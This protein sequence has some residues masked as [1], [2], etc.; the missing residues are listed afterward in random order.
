MNNPLTGIYGILIKLTLIVALCGGIYGIY[1]FKVHQAVQEAVQVVNVQHSAET[2]RQKEIIFDKSQKEKDK[3]QQDFDKAQKEK[4][5]KIHTLN[6]D[7][8]N[9]LVSLQQRPSRDSSNSSLSTSTTATASPRG[10]YP[11]ELFREDAEAF[12]LFARDAEEV[13]LGLLSCYR[14]YDAVKKSVESFSDKK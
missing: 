3:L 12:V 6:R 8:S 14:D 7:V 5:A 2:F 9:L 10:A 11:S 4:D 13:R 1:K